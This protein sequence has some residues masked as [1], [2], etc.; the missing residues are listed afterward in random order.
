MKEVIAIIRPK[1]VS[2][3]GKAL[4]AVGFPAMTVIECFGRGK[5]KGYIDV[6]LPECCVD[7]QKV[8]EEGEKQGRRIKYIP[9]RMISIV[10][11]DVDVPLVV[12]I[13]TKVNRTGNY[14][15]GKI[16]V[17]PVDDAVRIRTGEAGEVA[18]GN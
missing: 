18:V 14:G 13:I 2:K 6:N 5:Q 7:I 3:T 10:V 15:D 11:E 4:E 16:F 8:I 9:K 17:L 1:M 12:G